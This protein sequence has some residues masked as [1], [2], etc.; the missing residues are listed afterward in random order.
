MIDATHRELSELAAQLNRRHEL[1]GCHREL[2]AKTV[3]QSEYVEQLGRYIHTRGKA[4]QKLNRRTCGRMLAGLFSKKRQRM[5]AAFQAERSDALEKMQT[6]EAEVEKLRRALRGVS[7]ERA[8][9]GD[10]DQRYEA[11]AKRLEASLRESDPAACQRLAELR[12]T[13]HS[14]EARISSIDNALKA[15][16]EVLGAT[17][18]FAESL[19]NTGKTVTRVRARGAV[20]LVV[21]AA[22]SVA[23]EVQEG[24]KVEPAKWLRGRLEKFERSLGDIEWDRRSTTDVAVAQSVAP[25]V[26]LRAQLDDQFARDATGKLAIAQ[27]IAQ[28]VEAVLHALDQKKQECLAQFRSLQAQHRELLSDAVQSQPV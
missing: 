15:G 6:A 20:G 19:V 2:Y 17:R 1:D 22:V 10:V 9:L 27:H 24:G 25:L 7:A 18:L 5:I 12:G 13:L 11:L 4:L 3:S 28:Q 16:V 26:T 14:V 23:N 8:E 21:K